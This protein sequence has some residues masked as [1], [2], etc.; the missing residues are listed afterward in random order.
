MTD[1]RTASRER[2]RILWTAPLAAAVL[3]T[4][5]GC[6]GQQDDG[7]AKPTPHATHTKDPQAAQKRAVLAAYRGMTAAETR[8]YAKGKPDPKLERYAGNKALSGI[9]QT[10]LYYQDQGTVLRGKPQHAPKV[11]AVSGSRATLAD[12]V[13][14]S[15]QV[16]VHKKSGK[17]VPAGH[18][19]RRHYNTATAIKTDKSRRWVI[20][21]ADIDRDR[22]C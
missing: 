21:T 16:E 18:G 6:G 4:L 1:H 14:T 8:T 17:K 13:D 20:W 12:C 7:D 19:S 22:T 11:I 9:R 15:H 3:F 5:T 10:L 2:R